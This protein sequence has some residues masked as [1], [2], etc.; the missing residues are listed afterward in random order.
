LR[1]RVAFF[2]ITGLVTLALVVTLPF[3]VKTVVDDIVGSAGGRA[4]QITP[5][6]GELATPT[7]SDSATLSQ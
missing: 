6:E 3:S 1:D 4:F 7:V 5:R 2:I